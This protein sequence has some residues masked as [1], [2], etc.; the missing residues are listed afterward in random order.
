MLIIALEF[1]HDV[2]NFD[3]RIKPLFD[4]K[5]VGLGPSVSVLAFCVYLV[6]AM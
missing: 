1:D 4:T 3:C 5:I 2:G 6:F